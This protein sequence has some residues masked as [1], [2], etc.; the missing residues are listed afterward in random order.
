MSDHLRNWAMLAV[1]NK[2]DSEHDACFVV[3]SEE[4]GPLIVPAIVVTEVCCMLAKLGAQS[5]AAFLRSLAAE[6]LRVEPTYAR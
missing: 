1:A 4:P 5:E 6:E 2:H 3:L